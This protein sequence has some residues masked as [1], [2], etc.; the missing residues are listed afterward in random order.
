MTKER[1]DGRDEDDGARQNGA[2]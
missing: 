2:K 1:I